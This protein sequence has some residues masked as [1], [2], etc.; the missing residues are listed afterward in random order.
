VK[1]ILYLWLMLVSIGC[2]SKQPNAQIAGQPVTV[3]E[4]TVDDAVVEYDA[5]YRSYGLLLAEQIAA[6]L[7]NFGYDARSASARA[8]PAPKQGVVIT[9]RVLRI[10]GGN[11]T[12]RAVV[13]Y[14]AGQAGFGAEGWLTSPDGAEIARFSCQRRD[15][16]GPFGG[17]SEALVKGLIKETGLRSAQMIHTGQYERDSDLEALAQKKP[18]PQPP[19]DPSKLSFDECFKR[20]TELTS[21]TREECFDA[22]AQR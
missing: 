15:S 5:D 12:L 21:R 18:E 7:R 2:A 11:R 4:F 14:G 3:V 8:L 13:G 19:S 10:R 1:R 16:F 20:C 6:D 17:D 9:G 22:C